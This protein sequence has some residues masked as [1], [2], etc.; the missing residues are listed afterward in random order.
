MVVQVPSR[1]GGGGSAGPRTRTTA[2]AAHTPL[3]PLVRRLA[4]LILAA[5]YCT[6]LALWSTGGVPDPDWDGHAVHSLV[7]QRPQYQALRHRGGDRDRGGDEP[8]QG[9]GRRRGG[10]QGSGLKEQRSPPVPVPVSF[11]GANGLAVP[12]G[13]GG[14]VHEAQAPEQEAAEA[15]AHQAEAA[16][17]EEETERVRALEDQD[18]DQGDQ[19]GG[20]APAPA[21][22]VAVPEPP[23]STVDMEGAEQGQEQEQQPQPQ[24]KEQEWEWSAAREAAHAEYGVRRFGLQPTRWMGEE[25]ADECRYV[26]IGGMV[27]LGLVCVGRADGRVGVYPHPPPSLPCTARRT[28]GRRWT[29]RWCR[30]RAPTGSGCSRTSVGAGRAPSCWRCTCRTTKPSPR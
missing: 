22:A 9:R 12:W 17:G 29:S 10:E 27:G 19:E 25:E 14:V 7:Q 4:L 28:G 13:G 16:A 26:L 8:P 15:A 30:R 20:A 3:P 23:P 21:V 11:E 24:A 2:A 5:S 18:Q 6:L 1:H